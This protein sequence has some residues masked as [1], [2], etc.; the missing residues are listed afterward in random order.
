[1]E[2]GKEPYPLR[3]LSYIAR[4]GVHILG[5]IL[6]APFTLKF[7]AAINY[8]K[9]NILENLRSH[10]PNGIDIYYDNTGG[11]AL[12][13]ALKVLNL[14]GRVVACGHIS[15]YNG[16]ESHG[17]RN[18]LQVIAQRITIRGFIMTDFEKEEGENFRREFNEYLLKG[19]IIYKEDTTESLDGASEA[20]IG[21]LKGANFGKA[22][23]KIVDL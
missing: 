13:A 7:N 18:L 23:I 8:K 19:D 11:E 16:Q 20:F 5:F 3:N 10:A 21:M 1:M 6:L 17:I 4:K 9:G 15:V 2:T 22:V 14:H 12:E